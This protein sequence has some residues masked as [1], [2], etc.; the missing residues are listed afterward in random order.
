[1]AP[2]FDYQSLESHKGIEVNPQWDF[3]QFPGD[4][5]GHPFYRLLPIVLGVVGIAEPDGRPGLI[6]N[7]APLDGKV[8]Q[9]QDPSTM[10][11]ILTRF[12][13]KGK[14]QPSPFRFCF[15]NITLYD[16][17]TTGD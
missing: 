16:H 3:R 10:K 9:I 1:M 8:F 7:A 4:E 12:R 11:G 15:D 17:T 14:H 6:G 2:A 13:C 5:N